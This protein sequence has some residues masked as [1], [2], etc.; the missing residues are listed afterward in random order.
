MTHRPQTRPELRPDPL[1]A[2]LPDTGRSLA[3]RGARWRDEHAPE[4]LGADPALLEALAHAEL[5]AR[6]ERTLVILGERGTGKRTLARA[7]H[8]AGARSRRRP[9][10]ALRCAELDA[11]QLRRDL[12]GAEGEPGLATAAAG[13][14]L[15]LADIDRA[16]LGE[17]ELRSILTGVASTLRVILGS[18][19]PL[20]RQVLAAH[21]DALELHL[22][23]LRERGPDIDDLI[24]HALARVEG[25]APRLSAAARESLRRRSWP[26]N[27]RELRDTLEFLARGDATPIDL[28]ESL[29][30]AED[31]IPLPT[32]GLDLRRLLARIERSLID[33]ALART[34]GNRSQ[35]ARLLELNRTTLVEKLR[36]IEKRGG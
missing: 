28:G 33:Q 9:F 32:E 10:L 12:L 15:Y 18:S 36:R 34:G 24:E 13:G 22:P 1:R 20:D 19:R 14:T 11:A 8:R 27:V 7:I 31:D 16:R 25:P 3:E 35:A 29:D 23:P 26:G 21:V 4:I 17:F 6:S 5:A 2:P 30:A